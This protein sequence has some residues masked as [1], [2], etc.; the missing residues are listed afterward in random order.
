VESF[1]YP[2]SF[3]YQLSIFDQD[4]LIAVAHMDITEK[5]LSAVYCYYDDRYY[6]YSLG[7]FAIYKEIEI[8]LQYD[9]EYMYLGY[10]IADNSHMNYKVRYYPN[11]LLVGS[12]EW[13]D[14][15]GPDK[16]VVNKDLVD[17][18]FSPENAHCKGPSIQLSR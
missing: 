15:I 14:Y 12:G 8:A 18:G 9:L 10:Y 5:S 7:A 4:A 2:F 16:T 3:N 17:I 11:Q 6:H 1:H 13:R